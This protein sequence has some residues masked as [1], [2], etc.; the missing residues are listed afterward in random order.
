VAFT[1]LTF[2]LLFL[3]AVVAASWLA[4]RSR[5]RT[6]L[7]LGSS[8]LFYVACEGPYAW[9][10]LASMCGNWLLGLAL[11]RTT[12]VRGR[13][14]WLVLGLIAN[15]AL[16][17]AFKYLDFL[18]ASINALHIPLHLSAVT[19]HQPVGI[20]FFTFQGMAYLLGVARAEVAPAASPAR[21]GLLLGLYPGLLAG[22]IV[23]ATTLEPQ[24]DSARMTLVNVA[25]G[26]RRFVVGLAKKVLLADVL[27]RAVDAIVAGSA[28]DLSPQLA[29]L[30]L[31]AYTLQ[32]YLDFSGYS[33]MA[34]GA[35]R[36]LGL[37]YPENFSLPYT[38]RSIGEFWTRWHITLS[39]WFRDYVFLPISYG[40]SRRLDRFNLKPRTETWWSYAAGSTASMLLIGLWHGASWSFVAWGGYFA[41]L[42]IAE[43]TRIG[44]RV[45]KR[46]PGPARQAYAVAAVMIGWVLF[47]AGSLAGAAALF[48][49][50]LGVS[51]GEPSSVWRYASTDVV[52]ALVVGTAVSFG[53]GP[54]LL[55]AWESLT[56]R[57]D[58]RRRSV[59]SATLAYAG[60]TVTIV[61]LALAVVTLAGGTLTSFIYFQF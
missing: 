12:S 41:C 58:E 28:T 29:W 30:A 21:A 25:E 20:S 19:L 8:M 55:R 45:L 5:W 37:V 11:G 9:V 59:L 22:P 33:D 46:L 50:L 15:V 49:G 56:V 10:L 2:L 7:L 42:L 14:A 34:I 18:V 60:A 38:A 35:A 57:F 32:I 61:L 1:S 44:A 39:S 43:R 16:L 54:A 31:V 24:L 6:G 13:R 40:V 47:R 53:A 52:L 27:G 23:R 51:Y 48:K 36:M 4:G 17:V 26:T 3:P